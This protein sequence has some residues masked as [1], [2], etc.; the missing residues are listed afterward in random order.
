M[1]EDEDGEEVEDSESEGEKQKV[2]GNGPLVDPEGALDEVD[3]E[4]LTS[5]WVQAKASSASLAE[6]PI[7]RVIPRC[8]AAGSFELT[9]VEDAMDKAVLPLLS[10][11]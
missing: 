10:S 1:E 2:E 4:G 5:Y 11:Y 3:S 6:K 8:G 7:T 9:K